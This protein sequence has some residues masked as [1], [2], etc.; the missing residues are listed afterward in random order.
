MEGNRLRKVLTKISDL[1]LV[2]PYYAELHQ[3]HNLMTH[4]DSKAH[5]VW[6]DNLR[7]WGMLMNKGKRKIR[8]SPK[9]FKS[10]ESD[11]IKSLFKFEFLIK[12]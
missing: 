1:S 2:L 6:K 4:L 5:T 9:E 7:S 11:S 10:L 3:W 8:I 12:E